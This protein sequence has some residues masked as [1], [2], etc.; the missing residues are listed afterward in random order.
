MVKVIQV[1]RYLDDD[2]CEH[3]SMK[4]ALRANTERKLE[5]VLN[6]HS[7]GTTTIFYSFEIVEC[8]NEIHQ[9]LGEYLRTV[10]NDD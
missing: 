2:G 6:K 5:E 7:G 10:G 8:A 9:I 1:T 3:G 4:E